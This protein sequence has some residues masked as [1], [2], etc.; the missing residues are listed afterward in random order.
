LRDLKKGE[1]MNMMGEW[2]RSRSAQTNSSSQHVKCEALQEDLR[3]KA[4][5]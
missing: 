2:D 4:K 5:A 1:T 3:Q